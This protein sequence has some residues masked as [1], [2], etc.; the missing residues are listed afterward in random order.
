MIIRIILLTIILFSGLYSTHAQTFKIELWRENAMRMDIDSLERLLQKPMDDKLRTLV[1]SELALQYAFTQPDIGFDRANKSLEL[2]ESLDFKEGIAEANQSRAYC[3]WAKGDYSNS[4]LL[5]LSSLELY[6]DLKDK[7][8]V[9]WMYLT[10]AIIYRDARDYQNALANA[11]KGLRLYDSLQR[12]LRISYAVV[13]SILEKQDSLDSATEYVQRSAS[14]DLQDNEG[15]WG[16]LAYLLGN[17]QAKKN[18][19]DSALIHYRRALQLAKVAQIPKDIVDINNGMANV[20][21]K[22]GNIDSSIFFANEVLRNWRFTA[23]QKGVLEAYNILAGSYKL[24]EQKD[25]IIKYLDSSATL[26]DKLYN[27]EKE[28]EIQ[29]LGFNAQLRQREN[30]ER[31]R[32]FQNNLKLYSLIVALAVFLL[33]AFLLYRN[34]RH[35]QKAYALL[36]KQKQETD[37]QKTKVENTLKELTATQAQLI[38]SEK[39][40]SLG[41]LTAGIAHEIQN[42][43]NFVNNFSELNKE[44]INELE[45]E[46]LKA[47]GERNKE[48][49]DQLMNDIKQNLEKIDQHGKRADS[50]VKGMLQHSRLS[51]GQKEPTDI[52]ALAEEYLRLSYHGMRAKDK[53]LSAGQPGFNLELHTDFDKKVGKISVIPQDIARVLL[54]LYNNAFYSVNEKLKK[55]HKNYEP[56]VSVTTKKMNEKV[57]IAV[58]DNGTGIS[59]KVRDKIFQPFFTTKPAGQG[60]GLGLSLSYDIITKEHGGEIKVESKE[61]EGAEFVIQLPIH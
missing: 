23:Y 2:A 42:P 28:R 51:T 47:E 8:G 14:L 1:L 58:K 9:A 35:K 7:E 53:S 31:L 37:I 52:N 11:Q 19:Y 12:S 34:N 27:Q 21:K 41:E 57:I 30:A 17:I 38:Q 4:L 40:A 59:E 36:Q 44:L 29:N 33:I 18:N 60:T 20:H 3:F 55:N 24:K 50:I 6:E 22:A 13:G 10:L 26:N 61:G 46:R 43:L 16:W 32:Q 45:G 15:R 25:S 48:F 5:A 54:N 56:T 49:E 39:M